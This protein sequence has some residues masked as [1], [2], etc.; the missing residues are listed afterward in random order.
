VGAAAA[1]REWARV[2]RFCLVGVANTAVTLGAFTVLSALGCPAALGALRWS[3][4]GA[5]CAILPCVTVTLYG[6]S[7]LFV[8]RAPA[9]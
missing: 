5:E 2:V 4:L 7:R 8:F 6:L 1:P 9:L 3:H